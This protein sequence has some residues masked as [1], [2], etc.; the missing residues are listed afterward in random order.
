MM[1]ASEIGN[2]ITQEITIGR[3]LPQMM[4][5]ITDRQ[6]RLKRLFNESQIVPLNF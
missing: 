5:R 6:I 3:S 4:M 1:T 2:Q